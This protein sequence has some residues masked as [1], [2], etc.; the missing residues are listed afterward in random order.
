MA[1]QCSDQRIQ[2]LLANYGITQTGDDSD[3]KN[4]YDA[5]YTQASTDV[6]NVQSA[7]ASQ[8]AQGATQNSQQTQA[9]NS[10]N[11]PWATLMGQ[12]GL[13]ATGKLYDD[14]DAFNE[15]IYKM[16]ASATSPQDKANIAELQA[17]AQVVFVQPDE[18]KAQAASSQTQAQNAAQP[19]QMT[20]ADIMAQ[21]N[22]L[23]LVTG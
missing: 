3:I 17:E 23:F 12:V 7:N 1:L 18:S 16:Q 6:G 22:K 11:V 2:E 10:S 14:Y 4:L 9:Q 21:L 19:Q 20:G 13:T 5:I 15:Q 8:N